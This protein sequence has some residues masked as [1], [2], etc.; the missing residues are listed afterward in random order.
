MNIWI[1]ATLISCILYIFTFILFFQIFSYP[2]RTH[3]FW[4]GPTPRNNSKAIDIGGVYNWEKKDLPF[5]FIVYRPLCKIWLYLSLNT[6]VEWK[7]SQKQ[8]YSKRKLCA[9]LRMKNLQRISLFK[10][11]YPRITLITQIRKN[12]NLGS[13]VWRCESIFLSNSC[14]KKWTLTAVF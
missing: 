5:T 1:K 14:H 10:E 12:D 2:S 6:A 11:N 7:I 9:N 4:I 3:E 13:D 8:P